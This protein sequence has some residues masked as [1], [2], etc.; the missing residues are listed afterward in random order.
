[1]ELSNDRRVL[2][3]DRAGERVG[4]GLRQTE[5][6]ALEAPARAGPGEQQ[7]AQ[8]TGVLVALLLSTGPA[9]RRY[10]AGL[11]ESTG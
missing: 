4:G 11:G 6:E 8:D 1:M 5:W 2:R 9:I 10:G 3:D 7:T